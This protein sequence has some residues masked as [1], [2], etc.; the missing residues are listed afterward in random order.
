MLIF[1]FFSLI[2]AKSYCY[3][4]DQFPLEC[5]AVGTPIHSFNDISNKSEKEIFIYFD[6]SPKERLIVDDFQKPSTDQNIDLRLIGLNRCSVSIQESY[7]FYSFISVTISNLEAELIDTKTPAVV[8]EFSTLNLSNSKLFSNYD[9]YGISANYIDSD[10]NSFYNIFSITYS[11]L[12]LKMNNFQSITNSMKLYAKTL[13]SK[14]SFSNFT[15][16]TKIVLYKSQIIIS[17]TYNSIQYTFY[18]LNTPVII[19]N[20]NNIDLQFE[21]LLA[22]SYPSPPDIDIQISSGSIS[23]ITSTWPSNRPDMIKVHRT[24]EIVAYFYDRDVPVTFMSDNST[25][26]IVVKN[27]KASMLGSINIE[28]SEEIIFQAGIV[29]DVEFIVKN[30][31]ATCPNAN[32]IA[33]DDNLLLGIGNFYCDEKTEF[34]FTGMGYFVLERVPKTQ[35]EIKIQRLKILSTQNFFNFYLYM[36]SSATTHINVTEKITLPN[37]FNETILLHQYEPFPTDQKM[38]ELIGKKFNLFSFPKEYFEKI[39]SSI[40]IIFPKV[41]DPYPI[42]GFVYGC[43]VFHKTFSTNSNYNSLQI[44][45]ENISMKQ[46]HFCIDLSD[47]SKCNSVTAIKDYSEVEKYLEKDK[48]RYIKFD[49]YSN[50]ETLIASFADYNN[51]LK[52]YFV[53]PEGQHPNIALDYRDLIE[54][55]IEEISCTNVNVIINNP[56]NKLLQLTPQFNLINTTWDMESLKHVAFSDTKTEFVADETSLKDIYSKLPSNNYPY[57]IMINNATSNEIS[58]S[59]GKATIGDLVISYKEYVPKI[60]IKV[61]S[62]TFKVGTSSG[63]DIIPPISFSIAETS[64]SIDFQNVQNPNHDFSLNY[65]RGTVNIAGNLNLAINGGNNYAITSPNSASL[66]SYVDLTHNINLNVNGDLVLDSALIG[67]NTNLKFEDHTGLIVKNLYVIANEGRIKSLNPIK[68]LRVNNSIDVESNSALIVNDFDFQSNDCIIQ[69][70]IHFNHMPQVILNRTSLSGRSPKYV[71][72]IYDSK[73]DDQDIINEEIQ[74]IRLNLNKF[75]KTPIVVF[76][77]VNLDCSNWEFIFESE[78]AEFNGSTSLFTTQC[79]RDQNRFYYALTAVDNFQIH[80]QSTAFAMAVGIVS[81][82]VVVVFIGLAL[83][84]RLFPNRFK[85]DKELNND[86]S[87]GSNETPLI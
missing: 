21:S 61:A 17:A 23:F 34:M 68:K 83:L 46:N 30:V 52:I 75:L 51:Y 39:Q 31:N 12:N 76:R 57:S 55:K 8:F 32:I 79:I 80:T 41:M 1:F 63:N 27:A 84:F 24:A 20:D 13:D 56:D 85:Y 70:H 25:L 42:H 37:A 45:V 59:Q 2:S 15:H 22:L 26:N 4:E 48:V 53:G 72:F 29:G 35:I 77:G 49:V 73:F 47:Q 28:Y 5:I 3:T 11:N 6:T 50:S 82:L 33:S 69:I 36:D 86:S 40:D 78:Y 43:S 64:N 16:D 54:N 38:T 14:V 44:E 74:L 60:D 65:P 87:L 58:F 62:P 7:N 71:K 18:D 67:E 9:N 19:K 66:T 81:I 10:A